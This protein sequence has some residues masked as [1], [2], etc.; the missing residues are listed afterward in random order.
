MRVTIFCLCFLLICP[1]VKSY[2]FTYSNALKLL[3][4]LFPNCQ[5]T[6]FSFE[7][8][9]LGVI[10]FPVKLF[11]GAYVLKE[12]P[13]SGQPRFYD[14]QR[15]IQVLESAKK[16][17]FWPYFSEKME[18]FVASMLSEKNEFMPFLLSLEVF[19][20]NLPLYC[21]GVDRAICTSY[22]FMPTYPIR[23]QNVFILGMN[24]NIV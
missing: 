24:K 2:A 14:E 17:P 19:R 4:F 20:N 15:G 3:N 9:D 22:L 11:S 6:I 5:H 10:E 13:G 23:V 12:H 21:G 16:M 8:R 18:Y 7:N 1:V